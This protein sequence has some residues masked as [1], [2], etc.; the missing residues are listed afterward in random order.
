MR[1]GDGDRVGE[2]THGADGTEGPRR[3]DHHRRV[4]F[5]D[6]LG[7]GLARIKDADDLSI[8]VEDGCS[9]I[10]RISGNGDLAGERIAV[11]A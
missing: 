7:V 3:A 6:A 9:A 8:V 2:P 1:P 5:H 11:M 10:P 4:E